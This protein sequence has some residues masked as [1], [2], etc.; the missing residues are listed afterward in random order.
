MV[1]KHAACDYFRLRILQHTHI[2]ANTLHVV[3]TEQPVSSPKTAEKKD[4]VVAV[5]QDERQLTF[6][7]RNACRAKQIRL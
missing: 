6:E 2:Q 1:A 7:K 5:R 4:D 3:A